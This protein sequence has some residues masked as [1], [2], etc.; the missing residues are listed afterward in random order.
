[1][2]RQVSTLVLL[3]VVFGLG[4][5]LVLP[6]GIPY[7]GQYRSLSTSSGPIVPPTAQ[8]GDAPFV[9]IEVAEMEHANSQALFVDSR[10]PAEFRCGAIPGAVNVPFESLPEENAGGYIDSALGGV[11][12]NQRMIIY[13]SGEECD[14][15]LHLARN[16]QPLGYTDLAIFF[17]GAREWEKFGLPVERREK[18]GE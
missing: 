1:M 10:D 3:S 12:K 18:C 13:C 11:G 8:E 17:G 4:L 9:G 2:V 16:M 5:N 6:S 15:S 7:F 14:L